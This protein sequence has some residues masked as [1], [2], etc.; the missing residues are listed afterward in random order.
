MTL[1][2]ERKSALKRT[3]Q[4]LRAILDPSE[5]K[6][7]PKFWTR[8]ELRRRASACLKH[9]PA[10]FHID[11]LSRKAPEIM[12]DNWDDGMKPRKGNEDK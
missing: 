12:G 2:P 5:S 3:R 8:K 6:K 11:E 7:Y 9:F 10:D 4:F 1:P